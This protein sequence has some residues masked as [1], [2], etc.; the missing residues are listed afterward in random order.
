MTKIFGKIASFVILKDPNKIGPKGARYIH[1]VV[2]KSM[3]DIWTKFEP[4][5]FT[6][7]EK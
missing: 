7:F 2:E 4:K 1:F 3:M 5:D 6:N